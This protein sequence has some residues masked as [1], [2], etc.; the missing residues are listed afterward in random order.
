MSEFS[1]DEGSV[2][3]GISSS[4]LAAL[5][6]LVFPL[7]I[8]MSA[9]SLLVNAGGGEVASQLR[10]EDVKGILLMVGVPITVASFF[11][12]FYP[13]GSISRFTF[14]AVV[15]V[16][17]CVWIWLVTMGGN[18]T[19]EFEQFGLTLNFTGLVLLFILAAALKGVYYLVEMLSY[20]REWLA[21]HT[22]KRVP[23]SKI[24]P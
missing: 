11:A 13:K 18:L 15:T 14:G 16:L 17:V 5:K 24:V 6:Y 22:V 21:S 23:G 1:L 8:L 20:R 12:G 10:L 2:G 19:L 4:I 9:S 7:L 3:K